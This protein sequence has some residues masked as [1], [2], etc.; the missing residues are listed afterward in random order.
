MGRGSL[1]DIEFTVQLL[2][3]AHDVRSPATLTALDRLEGVGAVDAADAE[4]L[5]TAY[6][7]CER[8]RNRLFLLGRD[9]AALP[10]DA[11][12]LT[13]LARSLGTTATGLRNDYRRVTRRARTVVERRFYG[14]EPQ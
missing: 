14:M 8:T 9:G 6:E 5:R 4:A 10:Q 2:A 12:A 7:V 13:R 1:T 11:P 3:L